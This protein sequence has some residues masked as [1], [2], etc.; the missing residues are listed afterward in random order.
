LRSAA[1]PFII[2]TKPLVNK[3]VLIL[4]NMT[5]IKLW[6][7]AGR[8]TLI[9]AFLIIQAGHL[10]GQAERDPE[11]KLIEKTILGYIENFFLN[12][13]EK[14]APYLHDR[15]SK[16]GLGPDNQLSEDFSRE[17]LKTLMSNKRPLPLSAQRNEVTAIFR[18]RNVATAT[19]STGYPTT[20]WK[21][22]INLARIDGRWIIM[23]VFWNFDEPK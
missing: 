6:Q 21:E 4:L 14:M 7:H 19:L 18:D 11:E 9:T 20:R 13:Y 2:V 15:L 22:Y 12:D 23:D 17:A 8:V 5:T 1:Y 16:R 10:F 3:L